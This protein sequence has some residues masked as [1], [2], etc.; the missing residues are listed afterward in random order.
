LDTDSEDGIYPGAQWSHTL[1]H[2]L[3]LCDVLVFLN[4]AGSD[5]SKWCHTEVAVASDLG[6]HCYWLDLAPGLSVPTVL[7]SVQGIRF[8]GNL[9]D[10][11]ASLVDRLRQDG[12][13][14]QGPARWDERRPPYPGLISLDVEDSAVFFGRDVELSR[15]TER[16]SGRLGAVDGDLVVV[17]G[18][19][20]AGKSSLV[21]AGL[22]ARLAMPG[23]NWVVVKPFEPGTMPLH[24]LNKGLFDLASSTMSQAECLK[25]LTTDGIG[26]LAE[27]VLDDHQPRGKRLLVVLDQVEQL[28][29]IVQRPELDDF[30]AVL[31]RAL[32]PGSPV[33]IVLTV[34]SD[35]FDELQHLPV[36]GDAVHE[37]VV[38]APMDRSQLAAVIG[39]PA[40]RADLDF[41]AGLIA[42]LIDDA[43]RGRTT[44][45]VD[46]L[47]L[48]ACALR[49]MYDLAIGENRRTM[50][51]ADYEH[52]GRIEGA[53]ARRAHLAESALAQPGSTVLERLLPRFVTLSDSHLPMSRAVA[54]QQLSPAEGDI[55]HALEDE[56]LMTGDVDTVRLAHERLIVAWPT[57]ARVVAARREDF[58]LQARLERQASDWTVAAGE[59]LGREACTV[60]FQWLRTRA[61]PVVASGAVGEFVARSKSALSRRRRIRGAA[62]SLVCILTII[63]LGVATYAIRSNR[64]LVGEV[65]LA[66]SQQVAARAVNFLSTNSVL[67][68][69]LGLEA[70]RLAPSAAAREAI[71]TAMGRPLL[72][73]IGDVQ[74]GTSVAFSPSGKVLAVGSLDGRVL[75]WDSATG[76]QLR[77]LIANGSPVETLAFSS[78]GALAVGNEDG[79]VSVWSPTSGREVA[80]LIRNVGAVGSIAFSLDGKMLAVGT[81]T[82]KI[83]LW[84]PG[85]SQRLGELKGDGSTIVNVAFSPDGRILVA[86]T[87]D[88]NVI[89][90]NL[91]TGKELGRYPGNSSSV[92]SFA[93]DPSDELLAVGS[94]DGNV[95]LIDPA[96]GS[97]VRRF[98]SDDIIDCVAFSPDGKVLAAGTL[99]GNVYLW[100]PL[101]GAALG[102]LIGVADYVGSLAFSPD[103]RTLATGTLGGDVLLWDPATG[104]KLGQ[105]IGDASDIDSVC[106]SPNGKTLVATS[107]DGW[108]FLWDRAANRRID[109]TVLKGQ[110]SGGVALSPNG[111]FAAAIARGKL[112]LW[113]PTTGVQLGAFSTPAS[114]G[115][116][117]PS[118][119][120][121]SPAFSPNEKL[122]AAA[123]NQGNVVVWNLATR[124]EVDRL[125][126]D[127]STIGSFA[128]SPDSNLLVVGSSNV[129]LWD[130]STGKEVARLPNNES[131]ETLV[132]SF[133]FSPNG[134]WLAAGT[135]GGHVMLWDLAT[136][137]GV[138]QSFGDEVNGFGINF[139]DVAFSPNSKLL[140]VGTD[141]GTTFLWDPETRQVLDG[142]VGNGSGIDVVAF[143]PD[144]KTLVAGDG[145]GVVFWDVATASSFGEVSNGDDGGDEALAFGRGGRVLYV[146][147]AS[148]RVAAISE[149]YWSTRFQTVSAALCPEVRANLT[150]RQWNQY[151][152][153]ERDQTLCRGY[154]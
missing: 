12:L 56:R 123:T 33:T 61:D 4:S 46:S 75:L 5:S 31:A 2:K 43:M 127:G 144:G 95:L 22:A 116:S 154:S 148:G 8:T 42:R 40:R 70:L 132:D 82:G 80:R 36:I 100:N 120:L 109:R 69:L 79:D 137:R 27:W 48:L 39:G 54:R 51:P 125:V 74:P 92:D 110:M 68:T 126:G 134:K 107:A 73:A 146:A 88:G 45:A 67:G 121:G 149:L 44:E 64:E 13:E 25:R 130:V 47:P 152:P 98:T 129:V 85:T 139:A 97:M 77:Q 101:T 3:R 99:N 49:E 145:T 76:K 91:M 119:P 113:S 111:T 104:A 34:R 151:V 114:S 140:A 136:H 63:A 131:D 124:R 35:R 108:A 150:S 102:E 81:N 141:T 14:Q 38:L 90:W 20:G 133:A 29:A 11:I 17:V 7:Q 78:A 96:T 6:K 62:L 26:P 10:S 9:A 138:D 71:F 122:V 60:A 105:L 84:D 66:E 15:L 143:S 115:D 57:L 41:D 1:F 19:S 50:T 147:G 118:F 32:G 87:N 112:L 83:L 135:E 128:F 106:F 117:L 153:D 21:K 142:L 52:V 18:P 86:N 103:G 53:I 65:H 24:R 30:L 16:V 37:S 23:S 59:L 72:A 94:T 89:V 55:V 58:L 93:F 28:Q